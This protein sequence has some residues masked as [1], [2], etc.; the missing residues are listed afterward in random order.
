MELRDVAKKFLSFKVGDGSKIFL[1]YDVWQPTGCL[2][3]KY[4]FRIVYDAGCSIGPKLSSIIRDGEWYWPSARSHKLVEIQSRLPE[5]AIGREYLPVWKSSKGI[6]NCAETWDLSRV[7][8]PV[9][10]WH[11]YVWFS[12]AIPRH[13]FILWLVFRDALTTKERMCLWGFEGSSLCLFCHG[14]QENR[15]HLFFSCSFSRPI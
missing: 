4:G 5:V 3:D 6:Y 14:R 7:K 9:V 8:Y 15:K 11:K 2:L 12:L 13:S 1:W 10:E